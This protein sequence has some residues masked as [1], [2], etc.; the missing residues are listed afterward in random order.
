MARGQYD[1]SPLPLFLYSRH[2]IRKLSISRYEILVPVTRVH[3]PMKYYL[4]FASIM[5]GSSPPLSIGEETE[6]L[7]IFKILQILLFHRFFIFVLPFIVLQG[8][9]SNLVWEEGGCAGWHT[10]RNRLCSAAKISRWSVFLASENITRRCWRIELRRREM[11]ATA[12]RWNLRIVQ[13]HPKGWREIRRFLNL[14]NEIR[15]LLFL[16]LRLE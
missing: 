2:P 4:S 5:A 16:L 3:P 15:L 9:F 12:N 14:S 6:D 11:E 10:F 8:G 13:S 1:F 7:T